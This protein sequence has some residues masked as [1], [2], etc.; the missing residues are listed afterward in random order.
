MTT[1]V[2]TVLVDSCVIID[3]LAAESDSYEWAMATISALSESRALAINQ[4]IYAEIAAVY[5]TPADLNWRWLR[6]SSSACRCLGRQPS[7]PVRPVAF[8]G[9]GVV[10]D[11]L[12]CRTS[13][14]GL[15]P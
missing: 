7:Y 1:V 15:T 2:T 9:S 3:L 4:I 11:P 14:S 8:F 5:D 10:I 12:L 13:T 6:L